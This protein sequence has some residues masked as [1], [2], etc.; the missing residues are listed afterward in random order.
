MDMTDLQQRLAAARGDI[1][2]DLVV[3]NVKVVNV[4]NAEILHGTVGIHGGYIVG[5][6]N[7]EGSGTIDAGGAFMVPGLVEGHIHVES[8][9]L[10]IPGFAAVVLPHGTTTA[11]ID[12]HEIANVFGMD[13]IRYMLSCART[14]PLD[15]AVM[16]PSCVPA[17]PF[18]SSGAE[19][20]SR[21][22]ETVID[23]PD[24]GGIGELMNFPAVYNGDPEF[25]ARAA[26]AQGKVADGHAPLLTGKL[27]NAYIL[28]G[29][30]TDH[31]CTRAEEALEKLRN[32]MHIHIRYGS[33]EHNLGDLIKIVTPGNSRFMSLVSDD[34]YPDELVEYGHMNHLV[35]L[36]V[37]N[38]IPPVTAIQMASINTA[39]CYHLQ[40]IGAVAPGF[41]ADFFL[42][43]TLE[44]C[45]PLSVFKKGI[46]VAENG[47]CLVDTG[48]L[49]DSPGISM[50]LAPLSVDSFAVDVRGDTVRV[51]HVQEDQIIT[52]ERIESVPQQRGKLVSDPERDVLKI[53]VVER[54]HGTGRIGIGLVHGLGLKQGAIASTV[55]HDAHN[56]IVTGVTDEDLLCAVNALKDMGG[57]LVVVKDN[58][59]LAKLPLSVGGLMSDRPVAEVVAGLQSVCAAARELGASIDNPFMTVS[60][61]ALTPIPALK[62]TARGLFEATRFELVDLFVKKIT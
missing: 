31:E 62:I 48:K 4:F 41:Q 13:G 38:G 26:L 34:K 57:G 46:K 61:L 19:L 36:A 49:P 14:C 11:V 25:L 22:L 40:H 53:A 56:I 7:Y 52:E 28:A 44:Q 12:P 39:R 8:T 37:Q 10:T 15:I 20:T 1:P 60:F 43:E 33:T 51:I 58:S 21:D 55:A 42:T 23:K 18:E 5:M 50:Q 16:L 30:Q 17:S 6:G 45:R 32:G 9:M 2:C 29:V 27:L 47:E 59:V 35:R 3:T 54:H 24:V